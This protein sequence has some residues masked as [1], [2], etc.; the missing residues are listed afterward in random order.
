MD[1]SK[2]KSNLINIL[3]DLY[4]DPKIAPFL[5]FKGGT[6]SML[7]YKLPRFSV[8][9]DF[10]YLGKPE[11]IKIVTDRITKKLNLKYQ[12]KSQSTKFNTLFWLISYG[13]GEH[14]IKIEISTRDASFNHYKKAAL[15]GV[16]INL[17]EISD[18]IPHKMVAFTERPSTANRDIFDIHYFLSTEFATK[19]NYE[20]I[21]QRTSK[22]PKDFYNLL[23]KKLNKINPK[24]IL[25]GLGEVLSES[26]KI[27]AKSELIPEVKELIK[28]QLD[29][30]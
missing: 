9:L 2:H 21:K 25:T 30:I 8:D 16:N 12:I 11:D 14:T 24:N 23:L 22:D 5:G 4:K 28:K 10:D 3:M 7:F 6:A 19:I 20:I 26:Q 29:L 15:Y 1:I 18:I 17:L 13:V 27:W